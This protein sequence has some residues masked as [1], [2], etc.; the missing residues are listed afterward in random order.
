[1]LTSVNPYTNEVI[2]K[3][4][5]ST[6]ESIDRMLHDS[7]KDFNT[8]KDK[9]IDER[10]AYIKECAEQLKEN[11][12]IYA[13]AID[14]VVFDEFL[15][16]FKNEMEQ[17]KFGDPMD[18]HTDYGPLSSVDQKNVLSKQIEKSIEKGANVHWQGKKA[19]SNGAFI[20]PVILTNIRSDMPVYNEEV[21]GPVACMFSFNTEKE[22]ILLA[23]DTQ[24][25]LGASVW[26]RIL[27][28]PG[29]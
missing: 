20:N 19:P 1:M 16:T 28:M 25:G 5:E 24:F 17:L 27:I 6:S 13:A 14:E 3:Y 29:I 12:E 11:Q 8:W 10:V 22:A 9:S 26:T 21:F 18:E 4:E 7:D 15:E 23:N 2:E